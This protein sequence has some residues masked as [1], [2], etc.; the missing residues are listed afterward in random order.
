MSVKFFKFDTKP[1]LSS[2]VFLSYFP[3]Q[4]KYQGD[5]VNQR[6][7]VQ[8]NLDY[9]DDFYQRSQETF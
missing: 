8:T 7:S 3:W 2:A 4:D 5:N 9:L 1:S 6:K